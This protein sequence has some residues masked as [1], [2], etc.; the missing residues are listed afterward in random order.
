MTTHKIR[1]DRKYADDIMY[2]GKNFEVR[3][4]D[5]NY[6]VGDVL[7]F[8][9]NDNKG[10]DIESR[11]Y[12]IYYIYN[13]S[14]GLQLGYV[15][16]AIGLYCEAV[17]GVILSHDEYLYIKKQIIDWPTFIYM[18]KY[19]LDQQHTGDFIIEFT[20]DQTSG[21][22]KCVVCCKKDGYFNSLEYDTQYKIQD[23]IKIYERKYG[24]QVLFKTIM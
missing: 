11:S 3:Y 7:Q 15:V 4:N 14:I 12:Q 19:K 6:E 23:L 10:H 5:R 17:P 18:N 13:G 22:R 16:L 21:L 9:V 20:D 1:I 2:K 24:E 8:H